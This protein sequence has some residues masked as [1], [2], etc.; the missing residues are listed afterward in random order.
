[1]PEVLPAEEPEE[2]TAPRSRRSRAAP[3][4][5]PP[6]PGQVWKV[7]DPRKMPTRIKHELIVLTI[8]LVF[9]GLALAAVVV[10]ILFFVGFKSLFH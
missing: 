1:M 4:I 9:G 2:E 7:E 8:G 6:K 3:L 10:T 5:P